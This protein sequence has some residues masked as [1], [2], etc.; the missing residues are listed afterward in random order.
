MAKDR[1]VLTTEAWA[2]RRIVEVPMDQDHMVKFRLPDLTAWLKHGKIPNPLIAIADKIESPGLNDQTLSTE[3]RGAYSDLQCFIIATHLVEPDLLKEF[4]DED[5]AAK[6]V[7]ENMPPAD[8]QALWL[9]A[10]H[11]APGA[12]L[13]SLTDLLPF[14]PGERGGSD[15]G[16]GAEV[17]SAP[18]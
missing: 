17:G 14:R 11:I 10:F 15:A 13:E 18:E 9:A 2:H 8:R 6:W 7:E 16:D 12:L 5:T 4:G 1:T 3:E